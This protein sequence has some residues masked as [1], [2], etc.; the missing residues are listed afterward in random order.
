MPM[1]NPIMNFVKHICFGLVGVIIFPLILVKLA[2]IP[3]IS[4]FVELDVEPL[5]NIGGFFELSLTTIAYLFFALYYEKRSPTELGFQGRYMLI[6]LF[7][8]GVMLLLPI[9]SNFAMGYY[10]MVIYKGADEMAFVL[11]G[12]SVIAI[13]EEFIFRGILFRIGEQ[14]FGTVYAL[15]CVSLLFTLLSLVTAEEGSVTVTAAISL[16]LISALWCAIFVWTRNIW[17]VCLHHIA[18][19]YTEFAFGILD[20]HWRVSAP[21]ESSVS[22]P[23][24]LTGGSWGPEGSILTAII[25]ALGLV[26]LYRQ[27]RLLPRQTAKAAAS[28]GIMNAKDLAQWPCSRVKIR[29]NL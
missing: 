15:I 19:N 21:M 28:Q 12:L 3:M 27:T 24:V 6:A 20:E 25:C 5:R 11:F 16:F 13:G 23:I 29:D 4:I 9:L 26:F 2:I 22:G 10:Q 1:K 14:Y 7:A 17:V 18:W 8:G